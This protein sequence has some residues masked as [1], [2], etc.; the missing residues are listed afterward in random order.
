MK[1]EKAHAAVMDRACT[2][3][4][5]ICYALLAG[6]AIMFLRVAVSRLFYPYAVEWMEEVVFT[7]SVRIS[8]G[9]RLYPDPESGFAAGVYNPLYQYLVALL[10]R[11]FG[12]ILGLGRV[13][14]LASILLA[15][16]IVHLMVKGETN[17]RRAGFV[18]SSFFIASFPIVGYWYDLA[19]I[20]SLWICAMLA[21][22]YFAG[23]RPIT[24]PGVVASAA[25][26]VLSFFTKQLTVFALAVVFL[27]LL[28]HHRRHAVLFGSLITV[29]IGAG[30]LMLQWSSDG[31]YWFYVFTLPRG[32]LSQSGRTYN[33]FS[34]TGSDVH[35][36]LLYLVR[37]FPICLA[38]AVFLVAFKVSGARASSAPGLWTVL[39]AVFILAD[40]INYAKSHAWHNSFY[41]TVAF[42]SL[43]VG[44][45]WARI[46]DTGGTRP[47]AAAVFLL[48]VLC[49]LFM[50]LY[51]P[52]DH[53]PRE[54][55]RAEGDRFVRCVSEL[56]GETWLPHHPYYA[57][58]AGKGFH[59]TAE[60]SYLEYR[61]LGKL[62]KRLIDDVVEVRYDQIII[63]TDPRCVFWNT[64][65]PL[66]DALNAHY[67]V[68]KK[69]DY[70]NV[71]FK[72]S[73]D[74]RQDWDMPGKRHLFMP[75]EG[76]Q[77][78]PYVL[79]TPKRSGGP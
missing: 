37:Y 52:A 48:C 25:C 65:P 27:H 20:D 41:T 8:V 79:M 11:A 14:S 13:V 76:T 63:D 60:A 77:A 74:H 72:K 54:Q 42:T 57:Y 21:G 35:M 43:I 22:L 15:A 45:L 78:R 10:V 58:L 46:G 3:L 1:T 69:F 59:Y 17:S 32:F 50:L 29:A 30:I 31:W 75:V 70:G 44:A 40:G 23:R 24:A 47:L 12:P 6:L 67:A 36:G 66:T 5:V 4:R 49:Q 26:F 19:R 61:N 2:L 34:Y 71:V 56:K 38:V 33:L 9:E 68:A 73:R 53:I 64:I 16:L 28:V 55:D 51:D 39:F 18:A 62:L 7:D